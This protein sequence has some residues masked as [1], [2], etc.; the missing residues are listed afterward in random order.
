MDEH[1]VAGTAKNIG[2]KVE[3]GFGRLAGDM[4]SQVQGQVKQVQGAEAQLVLIGVLPWIQRDD[5]L[6]QR[7]DE[8]QG[9]LGRAAPEDVDVHEGSG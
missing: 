8:R 6:V 7:P 2:G 3:E 1:R 4:K 5:A 9:R